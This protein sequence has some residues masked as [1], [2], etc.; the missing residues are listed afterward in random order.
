ML[1]VLVV[2]CTLAQV[3]L[4]TWG[5]VEIYMRS[6][7]VWVD[8]PGGERHVPVMPGGALVGLVLAANLLVAQLRRLELSWKK[9]GLW[10][11]HAG[12]ILLVA[13]E[14][15]SAA[16]QVEHQL[17][18]EEGQ[19]VGYV[20]HRQQQELAIVD[21]SD[22]AVDDVHAI[23]QG[24]L[25]RRSEIPLAGTPITLRVHGY[26]RN[27]QLRNRGP[28]DPP[29]PATAGIGPMVTALELPVESRDDRMNTV[30]AWVEPVA[31]GR[32]LGVWM[33]SNALSAP[34]AFT[35]EGRS[36]QLLM[37][38]AREYLGYSMTLKKFSHDRY[39]GTEIPKNFSSLV[40]LQDKGRGEDRDVLIYMNQPLR[41]RGK[42]FYQASFGKGDT[43]SI[44]QVVENPGWLMPYA[45]TVLVTVG[46]LVH[47]AISL[48]RSMK[49]RDAGAA[50]TPKQPQTQGA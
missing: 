48:R 9:V 6:W 47:F 24:V 1:I 22:P 40:R 39:P 33:V 20:E 49:R 17:V 37:R 26:F 29:A 41:Y 42:T 35:W 46:L 50:A 34:Q 8:L 16:F 43:L 19:T 25:G 27:A 14:F 38:P 7:L 11:T 36:Y 3:Q 2:A 5:A 13:G 4:G 15:V 45:S 30:A 23:P 28:A 31:A 32:S 12:L 21:A 10:I 44:L 18:F